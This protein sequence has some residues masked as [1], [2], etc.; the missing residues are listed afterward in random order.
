VAT[1]DIKK[2]VS[3]A[4][5]R[6]KLKDSLSDFFATSNMNSRRAAADAS[7]LSIELDIA[8]QEW[9]VVS[10]TRLLFVDRAKSNWCSSGIAQRP[11]ERRNSLGSRPR[12]R[13]RA[14]LACRKNELR[15]RAGPR[16]GAI[17]LDARGY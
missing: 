12:D 8:W 7:D 3:A 5:L 2:T 15:V 1:S 4:A 16:E 13:Y 14:R 17:A 9:Q 6:Q 11:G 10:R